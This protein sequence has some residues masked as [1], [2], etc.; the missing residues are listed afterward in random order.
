MGI[1]EGKVAIITGGA[2]GMGEAHVRKFVGEGAK[3]V[4]ADLDV[5]NGK[6]LADELGDHALFVELDVTDPTSWEEAVKETKVVFGTVDVLVNNAG[7]AGPIVGLLEVSEDLYRSIMD[8]NLAGTFF[9]MQA[10]LPTM[11][12]NGKGSIVN[13]SSLAGMRYDT[14]V[15]PAYSA[16]K[17][18]IRGFT[19]QAAFE[20]GKHGIRVNA[21]MPG[22][23]MTPMARAALSDEAIASVSQHIPARRF[24]DASE[25]SEAVVFLASDKASYVSGV[26][27]VVDGGKGAIN[28]DVLGS[29]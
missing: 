2:K 23:I 14:T 6:K 26:D 10:V 4:V 1:L 28:Q 24:A 12:E 9:G 21:V 3:V 17:F 7:I 20:F 27:L 18:A 25:V 11:V 13:I 29:D 15:N 8:I 16:S 19:K 22:A 5:A